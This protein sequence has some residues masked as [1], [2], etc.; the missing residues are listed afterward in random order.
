MGLFGLVG[1]GDTV[2]DSLAQLV[3]FFEVGNKLVY[4]VL[5]LLSFG[6]FLL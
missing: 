6:P 5:L 2:W 4:L 3:V 1:S